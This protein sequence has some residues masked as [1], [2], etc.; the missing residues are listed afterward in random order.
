ME[1]SGPFGKAIAYYT[2]KNQQTARKGIASRPNADP[3]HRAQQIIFANASD[4]W[5]EGPYTAKDQKAWTYF[6]LRAGGGPS[7]YNYFVSEFSRHARKGQTWVF[8]H[9]VLWNSNQP[10]KVYLELRALPNL[11]PVFARTN[12]TAGFPGGFNT[13]PMLEA[14]NNIWFLRL[15]NPTIQYAYTVSFLTTDDPGAFGSTGSFRYG[16]MWEGGPPQ[17]GP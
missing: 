10:D 8:L 9:E 13:I 17:S 2:C 3:A 4:A 1:A 6:N 5:H 12:W 11:A 16:I 14:P 15:E 7:G